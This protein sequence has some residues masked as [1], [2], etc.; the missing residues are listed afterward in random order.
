[1]SYYQIE[2]DSALGDFSVIS[3]SAIFQP[4]FVCLCYNIIP[5]TPFFGKK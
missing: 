4:R 3:M 1:M 5:S 2:V